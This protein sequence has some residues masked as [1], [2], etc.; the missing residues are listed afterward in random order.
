MR[1]SIKKSIS[2]FLA[3]VMLIVGLPVAGLTFEARAADDD[4]FSEGYYTYEV[5]NGEATITACDNSISGDVVV[6]DTLGG[7][8]VTKIGNSAFE[9][10]NGLTSVTVPDSVTNIDSSAFWQ[11]TGLTSI[12]IP[13]S[14]TSIGD[15]AFNCSGLES[16]N[17]P[18]SVKTVG[19][20]A[21]SY[22]KNLTSVNISNGIK[23]ISYCMFSGN[24]KLTQI[25]IPNSVESIESSAFS[26][27][28]GLTSVVIPNSVKSIKYDAFY[29]CSALTHITIPESV[30]SIKSYAF[31]GTG[32][33]SIVIPNSITSIEGVFTSCKS[34]TDIT[35][36]ESVTKIDEFTFHGCSNIE[37]I[38]VSNNNPVYS[39]KGNCLIKTKEK[40]LVRG[41]RNSV[42]PTDGSVTKIGECAYSYCAGLT[43]VTIPNGV[44]SIGESAFSNC[45]DL[46]SI[47][48]PKSVTHIAEGS[49]GYYQAW[50][51]DDP[52]TRRIEN[53]TIRGY[54]GSE[55]ETYANNNEFKFV[56]LDE[57]HTHTF[58]AWIITKEP[59]V[60][61]VGEKQR[62]CTVC[63]FTEKS[64]IEKLRAIEKKDD[65]TGVSVICS[66]K[67]YDGDVEISVTEIFDGT[68]YHILNTEKGN[69]QKQLFDIATM[70]DGKKVQPN[71]SVFVKIPL[72]AGYNA[73]KTVVYYITNDGQLE[74]I[75]SKV[76]DGYIIFETTHFSFYAIV[77]ETPDT[78]NCP[79]KCHKT[80]F[81]KFIFKI[82]LLFQKLFKLNK[83]CKCGIEHY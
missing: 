28:S 52:E 81:L 8:P 15:F 29:G 55:A 73:Q 66:Y 32:L 7:Y 77:D 2:L 75:E 74:K 1:K 42:I 39:S 60:F 35:I 63:G 13:N 50:I 71:G 56:A 61:E 22:C 41:C 45:M 69:F 72:P 26:M 4:S 64:E 11:C 18:S 80:G 65:T 36:P 51:N 3:A 40:E 14:V 20:W 78:K 37:K 34:L 9:Y 49:L 23:N 27:C 19:D 79:C 38:E 17:I 46:N 6:P 12:T 76:E 48:I 70:V 83:V 10:C 24:S 30:T 25:T 44:I 67:S 68:S 16:I 53:F 47:T 54:T 33:T 82:Q 5:E 62:S 43:S 31:A 59:T 21:F 57:E 58:S